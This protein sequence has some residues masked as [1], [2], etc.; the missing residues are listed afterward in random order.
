MFTSAGVNLRGHAI[1][2]AWIVPAAGRKPSRLAQ[3]WRFRSGE[4]AFLT[5]T[6]IAW[7]SQCQ[8]N[9][10]IGRGTYVPAYLP[11]YASTIERKAA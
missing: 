8:I 4:Y 7:P 3:L 6:F 5:R 11:E 10:L 1:C 9:N 2:W